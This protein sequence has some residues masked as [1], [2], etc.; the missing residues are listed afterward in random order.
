MRDYRTSHTGWRSWLRKNG[1]VMRTVEEAIR[2]RGPLGNADFRRPRS[3]GKAGGWWSWKP[4]TFALHYLW[5]T[6]RVL[7]HS[8]VHFQKRFDLG[9]RVF[10]GLG[11]GEPPAV[12]EFRRWHTRRA[13]HAMGA[14][15]EMDLRMYLTFPRIGLATRRRALD[16]MVKSGE[17]TEVG[18]QGD[19]ARWFALTEDLPALATAARARRPARGTTL[20]TPFDSFLWHRERTR[21]LFGFGYRIEVYTPGHK[22]T[23]GYYTLPILHDG[24]LIGRLDPKV[25]RKEQR[26]EVRAVHF[27]RWFAAGEPPPAASWGP[28]DLDQAMRGVAEALWSLVAFVDAERVTVGRV[29][30]ARFGVAFKRALAE[31]RPSAELP[32]P[33][34]SESGALEPA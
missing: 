18:I 1:R 5:M 15:T 9:E 25:H 10:P 23:H 13:L 6:G 33:V 29:A 19:R 20:L 32:Q 14:A 17:V 7:I 30:P 27:E 16:A 4:A 11:G 31:A 28:L 26:L 22:R 21:R 24:Q 34:A 3:A 8:R 2:D 12:D